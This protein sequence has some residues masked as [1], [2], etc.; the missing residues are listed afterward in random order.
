M[1]TYASLEV[2]LQTLAHPPVFAFTTRGE[3]VLADV[4]FARGCVLLFGP[5][6]RGLPPAILEGLTAA[7]RVRLPMVAGS[8]S[9]NLSNAVAVAVYAAWRQQ[10]YAGAAPPPASA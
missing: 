8:R 5:E 1:R 2:C 3:S 10:D 6:T 7:R 9:L 4:Q